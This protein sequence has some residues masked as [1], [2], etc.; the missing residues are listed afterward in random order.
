MGTRSARKPTAAD[1]TVDMF[2]K[3]TIADAAE[4]A[5]VAEATGEQHDLDEGENAGRVPIEQDVTRLREVAF[6]GQEWTSKYFGIPD[7]PGN[8]YRMSFRGQHYYLET[9]AGTPGTPNAYGYTGLMV[10]ERD[11]F[12]MATVIVAAV[13]AKQEREK[14]DAK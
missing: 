6:Q 13:R 7:A 3:A 8:Q 12:N 1:R 5:E 9:L 4:A 10:H 2:T 14:N 11:L